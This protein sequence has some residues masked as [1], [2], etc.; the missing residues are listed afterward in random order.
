MRRRWVGVT[1]L[2]LVA[3]LSV[4][5]FA[6]EPNE[7][8]RSTGGSGRETPP[9][10]G[11]TC[12]GRSGPI[13]VTAILQTLAAVLEIELIVANAGS[14]AVR[15]DPATAVLTT[16]ESVESPWTA[17]QVKRAHRD[18]GAYILAGALFPPLLAL[19]GVSQLNFNRYVDGRALHAGE[20]AAGQTVRG[21]IFFPMPP[22]TQARAALDLAGIAAVSGTL[23]PLRLYCAL[24][25][26]PSAQATAGAFLPLTVALGTVASSGAV[27]VSVDLVEFA[28]DYTAIELRIS[29]KADIPVEIFGAMVNASVRDGAGTIYAGRPARG[30]FGDRI[31][32]KQTSSARLVFAPLP[33]P[34]TT[35]VAT[36]TIP[37]VW[38]GPE[39]AVDLTVV[40]RF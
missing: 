39:D 35:A 12:M 13:T 26:G 33:L 11:P 28:A 32:A 34:P 36:L 14:A 10:A 17:D 37:R 29:N 19:T 2:L 25:R 40:L 23:R 15:I 3:A 9:A 8:E 20:V 16:A 6:Q 21:S 24:P 31:P 22:D 18:L 1:V 38:F 27:E 4:P 7:A 30:D 5:S